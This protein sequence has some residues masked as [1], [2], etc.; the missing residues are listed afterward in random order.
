M[1]YEGSSAKNTYFLIS[2]K[3]TLMFVVSYPIY[4]SLRFKMRSQTTSVEQ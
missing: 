2:R 4:V 1:I 3:Y